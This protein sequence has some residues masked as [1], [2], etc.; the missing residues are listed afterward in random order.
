MAPFRSRIL[1]NRIVT[2]LREEQ[3]KTGRRT[4]LGLEGIV[5]AVANR[6]PKTGRPSIGH[7]AMALQLLRQEKRI[8]SFTN[9]RGEHVY[10]VKGND[11][12]PAKGAH[13][14]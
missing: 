4:G 5:W 13:H 14:E 6:F 9:W 11:H 7:T 2:V 10:S 3:Q 8:R 1:G 12:E